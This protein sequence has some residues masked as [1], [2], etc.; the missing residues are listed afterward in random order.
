MPKKVGK[1]CVCCKPCAPL[2]PYCPDCS[3]LAV[4]MRARR[5]SRKTIKAIWADVRKKKGCYC[6]YTGIKLDTINRRSPWYCVFDHYLPRD[7]HKIVLT[8]ALVNTMKADQTEK[9]FWHNIFQL[10]DLKRKHKKFIKKPIVHWYR[11]DPN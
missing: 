7:S 11:L 10:A 5:F 1:C 4:R 2:S 6:H 9:E 3:K 8:S